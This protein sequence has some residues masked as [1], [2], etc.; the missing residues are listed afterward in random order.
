MR[1][2]TSKHFNQGKNSEQYPVVIYKASNWIFRLPLVFITNNFRVT[3]VFPGI[4]TIARISPLPKIVNPS[5]LKDY[6]PISVQP[7]HSK[8][9]EKLVLQQ[10]TEFIEK[11]LIYHKFQ[12]G[13]RKNHSTT[14]LS[15]KLYSNIKTS[16]NKSEI[17]IAI[18]AD[19]LYIN[20]ENVF[21][22]FFKDFLYI[23]QWII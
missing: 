6:W 17:T 1:L 18:F 13:Y 9:Y 21:F 22:N 14:T 2:I 15:M 23:G 20:T 11:Q 12:P 7:I 19:Y 3:S 16:M 5:Q 4:W 8:I 10:V